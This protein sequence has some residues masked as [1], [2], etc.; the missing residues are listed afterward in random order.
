M[1][2][3]AGFLAHELSYQ[4]LQRLMNRSSLQKERGLVYLFFHTADQV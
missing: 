3:P 4:T 2:L 1:H